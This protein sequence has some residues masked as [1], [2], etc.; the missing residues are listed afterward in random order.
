V[1][2]DG[3]ACSRHASTRLGA[4][5]AGVSTLLHQLIIAEAAAV[6]L[7]RAT[8]LRAHRTGSGVELRPAKHE[9]GAAATDLGA[10]I[11]QLNVAGF[12]MLSPHLEAMLGR[13]HADRVAAETF[14]DALLHL[15]AH[16]VLCGMH[17]S[18]HV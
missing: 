18:S 12:S 6:L 3:S 14:I 8:D 10:I 17:D 2:A 1:S 5:A 13:L 15:L 7:A 4:A 9:A 11:Q 16:R